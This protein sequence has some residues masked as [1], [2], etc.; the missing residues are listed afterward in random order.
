[1]DTQSGYLGTLFV[2]ADWQVRVFE[3]SGLVDRLSSCMYVHTIPLSG[4][5]DRCSR[6]T[7]LIHINAQIEIVVCLTSCP[8]DSLCF[9]DIR[10]VG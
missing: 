7:P 1:M 8:Y 2:L 9:T 5:T 4:C 10:G 6:Y 3:S